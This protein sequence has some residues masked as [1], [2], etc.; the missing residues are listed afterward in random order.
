M[1]GPKGPRFSEKDWYY[2]QAQTDLPFHYLKL[3]VLIFARF[4]LHRINIIT[5]LQVFPSKKAAKKQHILQE[6]CC[7][8]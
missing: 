6:N 5:K 1:G 4:L 7:I 2:L 3:V 8:L